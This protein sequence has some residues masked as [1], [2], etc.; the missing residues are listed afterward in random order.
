MSMLRKSE[1]LNSQQ[2]KRYFTT[3]RRLHSPAL[4]LIFHPHPS[5]HGAVVVPKKVH[6]LAVNRNHL[7]RR[8]Y[9]VLYQFK[10][11][12]V[13]GVWL[14]VVKPSAK[15]TTTTKLKHQLSD[16]LNRLASNGKAG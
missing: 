16:L 9:N 14:V 1:R 5:F 11:K 8:L 13:T 12:G 6:K 2:F 4:T 7:R 15:Q 3:G 10:L